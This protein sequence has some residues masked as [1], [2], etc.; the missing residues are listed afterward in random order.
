[1]NLN[2]HD[3]PL[4]GVRVLELSSRASGAYA[5]WLLAQLG[6]SVTRLDLPT[7]VDCDPIAQAE[8]ERSL[9][10]DKVQVA[11]GDPAAMAAATASA[12]VVVADSLHDDA[13]DGAATRASLA[14][15]ADLAPA[16]PVIDVSSHRVAD[17]A[18]AP[19]SALGAA[20]TAGMSWSLGHPGLEPLALPYDL[21]D[22]MAGTEAASAAALSLVLRRAS[23]SRQ[24]WD[25]ASSD[26]LAMYVGQICSNF[27]PYERPW[28]RDG[29]RASMSGGSYPAAMFACRDGHVSIMCRTNREWN[30]LLRAMGDPDWSQ[31]PKFEDSRVVARLHADEA[32]PHLVAWT[33]D[34]TRDEIFA[35]GKEFAFPVAPVLS[36]Q[37]A[38]AQEQFSMRDFIARDS[39]SVVVGR[40]WK[41]SPPVAS[42]TA[43]VSRRAPW[44]GS[45]ATPDKPLAGLR[46]LD[47][48]WVWSGPMVTAALHDLGAEILKIENRKRADPARLRGRAYRDGVPVDGPELEVTPYFNQMNHGKR[49]IALDIATDEGAALV[50]DLAAEC[51]V[52]VENMRPG[53][54]ERRGL[55]YERLSARNPGIVMLSMSLMGQTGPMRSV[56]GYAPVM[57]GLAG[58]DS[59]VGYDEDDLIGLFNPALGDPNGAG[60]A[61]AVLLAALAGRQQT[62]VGAWIDLSQVEALM[63]IQRIAVAE[64]GRGATP[65]VRAN[66]HAVFEPHGTWRS[67]GDDDWVTVVARTDDERESLA[68]VVGAHADASG[69]E[70]EAALQAWLAARP[71]SAAATELTTAGIAAHP[72]LSFEAMT[73]SDWA[74]SRGLVSRVEHPFLGDQLMFAVPWKC[75]GAGYS[76]TAPAPLLGADTDRVL[77]DVLGL[78]STDIGRFRESGVIE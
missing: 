38:L 66:R 57:S 18:R 17:G 72:V 35:L 52:V 62:G 43:V 9:H 30:G 59:V 61:L 26:V 21:P 64:R 65:A 20:A 5:G 77:G 75:N 71:A 50:L 60:H 40:P 39:E 27:L 32:D 23:Q 37:E 78:A 2:A 24:V 12:D 56:G 55:H 8:L 51:D 3:A 48:S 7:V 29:A 76:V 22:F 10:G 45:R 31:D 4:A 69:P 33:R 1:M 49:S 34:R 47:L 16:C 36:I 15:L 14:V 19:S 54:L 25:V 73:S 63:S 67:L 6:A 58:L 68:K 46:V 53:A 70:L 42:S 13:L 41:L 44:D 74:R 28:R 11:S